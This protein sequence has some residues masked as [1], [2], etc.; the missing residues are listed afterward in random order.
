VKTFLYVLIL[1]CG[2]ALAAGLPAYACNYAPGNAAVGCLQGQQ[3]FAPQQ[4]APPQAFP[5]Q[6]QGY[7]CQGAM[8]QGGC[9]GGC[10]GGQPQQQMIYYV[11]QA[12]PEQAPTPAPPQQCDTCQQQQFY[13]PQAAPQQFY[14]QPQVAPQQQQ[15]YQQQVAPQR[16]F[17]QQLAP[18][19]AYQ[20]RQAVV[21][22]QQSYQPRLA[23]AGYAVAAQQQVI[24]AQQGRRHGLHLRLRSRCHGGGQAALLQQAG[25]SQGYYGSGGTVLGQD[26]GGYGSNVQQVVNLNGRRR[27]FGR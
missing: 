23:Q 25:G 7:G 3:V 22:A 2:L 5:L 20:P 17:Q 4:Y 15:F 8:P 21:L 16:V 13:Q 14:Q 6:Q 9:Y 11:P 1:F 24:L 26:A 19:M 18:Q 12:A 27:L 10:Y